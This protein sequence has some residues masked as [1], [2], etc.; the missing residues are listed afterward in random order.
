M[1]PHSLVFH[2]KSTTVTDSENNPPWDVSDL[3][4]WHKK[5]SSDE[6]GPFRR[7]KRR[8]TTVQCG[9]EMV[10][11]PLVFGTLLAIIIR[12]PSL[13]VFSNATI[14]DENDCFSLLIVLREP[15]VRDILTVISQNLVFIGRD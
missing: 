9:D 1:P 7:K 8:K 6:C 13:S 11:Y 5:G 12:S 15:I 10:Y 14:D 3:L 4:L 2:Q